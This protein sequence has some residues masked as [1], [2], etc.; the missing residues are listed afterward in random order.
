LVVLF[1][2]ATDLPG[3]ECGEGGGASS[4]ELGIF[5]GLT[6]LLAGLGVAAAVIRLAALWRRLDSRRLP[7]RAWLA[8]PPTLV[9]VAAVV[10]WLFGADAL[11]LGGLV[12]GPLA[13]AVAFVL[14]LVAWAA[15][16]SA[17]DVGVLLP[18]YLLGTALICCPAILL[19]VVIGQSGLGC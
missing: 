1:F 14:L 5:L 16:R 6:A 9:V 12:L 7:A 3:P 11:Y 4:L 15:G 2:A 10:I 13:V 18:V 19:L 17:D 8:L